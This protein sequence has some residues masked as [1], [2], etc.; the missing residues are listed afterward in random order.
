[1]RDRPSPAASRPARWR[2]WV[3]R[4][5]RPANGL[6]ERRRRRRRPDDESHQRD[7]GPDQSLGWNVRTAGNRHR[8]VELRRR[9]WLGHRAYRRV[10]DDADNLKRNGPRRP[11][12][13]GR[14]RTRH[15]V[16]A[17][18]LLSRKHAL[19]ESLVD[20]DDRFLP[21]EVVPRNRPAA[22]E[23]NAHGFEIAGADSAEERARKRRSWN[24]RPALDRHRVPVAASKAQRRA[25]RGR[26]RRDARQRRHT[27]E[28]R[29]MRGDR[30][31]ARR[32]R[33]GRQRD[34][35]RDG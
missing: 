32:V 33:A 7:V 27:I 15:H 21:F 16:L 4:V 23:R 2:A 34:V 8:H 14:W 12:G 17:D 6:Q 30:R 28:D 22:L 35:E 13:L 31:G 19:R 25:R 3:D 20:D 11:A 26:R 1:M 18:R 9:H 24:E 10:A 5:N 29:L